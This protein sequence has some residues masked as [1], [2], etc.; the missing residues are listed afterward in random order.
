MRLRWYIGMNDIED[1]KKMEITQLEIAKSEHNQNPTID[2]VKAELLA[3]PSEDLA[4][5]SPELQSRLLQAIDNA[6]TS[7]AMQYNYSKTPT[8]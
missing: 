8:K 7:E 2:P 6:K 1:P 5:L 4:T 3:R